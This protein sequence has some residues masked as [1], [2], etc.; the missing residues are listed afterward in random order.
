MGIRRL[1]LAYTM[2]T[3]L[4]CQNVQVRTVCSALQD[5]DRLSGQ[6]V[7]VRGV[8][9]ENDEWAAVSGQSCN[10]RLNVGGVDWPVSIELVKSKRSATSA[11]VE[12]SLRSSFERAT[13]AIRAQREAGKRGHVLATFSGRLETIELKGMRLADGTMVHFG[14]GHG[15]VFPAR[16]IVHSVRDVVVQDR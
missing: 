4:F 14:F 2:G 8:W 9:V 13:S 7:V 11:E 10:L 5:R 12:S 16:L 15:G 3:V 1:Y 6:L